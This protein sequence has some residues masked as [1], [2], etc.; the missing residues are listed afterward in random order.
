MNIK[1]STYNCKNIYGETLWT[2]D[3]NNV[4][5]D[6]QNAIFLHTNV[7]HAVLENKSKDYLAQLV[8]TNDFK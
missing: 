7:P 8:F 1:I 2:I 5:L 6:K 4:L 3:K